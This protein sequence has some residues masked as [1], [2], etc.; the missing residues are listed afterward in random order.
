MSWY[1]IMD[2]AKLTV[3]FLCRMRCPE[4][5]ARSGAMPKFSL[6]PV[7]APAVTSSAHLRLGRTRSV[8]GVPFSEPQLPGERTTSRK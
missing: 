1:P 3:S 5:A 2:D 6:I 8:W 4:Y 7:S